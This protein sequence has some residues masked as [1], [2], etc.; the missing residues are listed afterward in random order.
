MRMFG[1]LVVSVVG[2]LILRKI[3]II[4]AGCLLC[5]CSS[6]QLSQGRAFQLKEATFSDLNGWKQDTLI[7]ALPAMKKSCAQN[8][9]GYEKFC[10]GL[11]SIHSETDLRSLIEGTLKPYRVISNGSG[12]GK[13]TG[14]YEAELTGTRH[15]ENGVQLPIYGVPDGY[16][17][18]KKYATRKDIESN[19]LKNAPIIAWA[20]NPIDL[21][22]MHVQGSGRLLTPEGE[23]LQLGYAGN[24]GRSFKG[25]GSIMKDAGIDSSIANSMPKIR[26]WCLEHP[27]EARSLMQKNERYIFFKELNGEGPIGSAGVALTPARSLAVDTKYIPMHTPMWLETTTPDGAPIRQMMVAQD[28]G[29]AIQ[30]GIRADFF[31]GYGAAA[32]QTAGHMNQAG[33]YYLLLPR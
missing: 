18:G 20:D 15:H 12:T 29:S 2:R 28:T 27:N 6:H 25:L 7:S 13:I 3:A 10:D 32:F 17:S 8:P 21:F 19:G 5:S 4:C 30:G 22:V 9:S 31:W 11:A 24:N 1:L 33:S 26:E 14:Y 16:E 23:V